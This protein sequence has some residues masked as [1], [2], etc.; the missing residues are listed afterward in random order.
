M[1]K[2]KELYI[3]IQ[4]ESEIP[5]WVEEKTQTNPCKEVASNIKMMNLLKSKNESFYGDIACYLKEK[6]HLLGLPHH[7]AITAM[8]R[9]TQESNPPYFWITTDGLQVRTQSNR[10][11]IEHVSVDFRLGLMWQKIEN[12]F[13]L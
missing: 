5:E 1:S 6:F 8:I 7:T 12:P 2:S 10:Y 4:E 9:H 11:R 3:Q 13:K